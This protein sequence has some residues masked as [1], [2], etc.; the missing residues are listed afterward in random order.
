M[1]WACLPPP[2]R[3]FAIRLSAF[4][5]PVP[6]I[7]PTDISQTWTASASSPSLNRQP[8]DCLDASQGAGETVENQSRTRY[9]QSVLLQNIAVE[10][11][12]HEVNKLL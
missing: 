5:A 9:R 1:T 4:C 3:N 7:Q 6:A 12:F 8:K 2:E 10:I 11:T